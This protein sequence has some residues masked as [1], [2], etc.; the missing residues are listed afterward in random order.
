MPPWLDAMLAATS[1]LLL[2][3]PKTDAERR[4]IVD[5]MAGGLRQAFPEVPVIEAEA[6]LAELGAPDLVLVDVRQEHERAISTLPGAVTPGALGDPAGRR[7]LCYCTIGWRSGLLA[8]QLRLQGTDARNLPGSLLR[9][10]HVGG[11]LV[12]DGA[13]TR[14]LHVWDA[15]WDLAPSTHRG[16]W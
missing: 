2:G 3:P 10:A 11:P 16:V 8:R 12:R 14:E 15:R 13:P 6:L 1:T 5:R 7:V 4:A 9:W